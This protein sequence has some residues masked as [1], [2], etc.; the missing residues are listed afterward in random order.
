MH[1]I[2]GLVLDSTD[3]IIISKFLGLTTLARYTNYQIVIHALKSVVNS[4]LG[5]LTASLGNL[6]A[7]GDTHKTYNIHKK[8]FFMN[9]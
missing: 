5:G 3:N 2:G 9:F 4:I 7:E 6:I 8:V 1:K